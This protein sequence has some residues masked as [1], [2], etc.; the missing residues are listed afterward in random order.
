M[1]M[2]YTMIS[3]NK[4]PLIVWGWDRKIRPSG[5]LGISNC[6]V[7]LWLCVTVRCGNSLNNKGCLFVFTLKAPIIKKVLCFSRLLKCLISFYDKSVD[8]DQTVP[9]GTVCSGFTLFAFMLNL[10]VMLDNYL[11]QTISADDIFWCIFSWRFKGYAR[12]TLC[13]RQPRQSR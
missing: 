4:N 5:S 6:F 7:L 13:S 10:S 3:K 8:P 2:R 1:K 12:F 9:I 11:Q